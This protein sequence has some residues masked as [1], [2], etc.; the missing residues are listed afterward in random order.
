MKIFRATFDA[1]KILYRSVLDLIK[2][3]GMIYAAATSFYFLLSFFPVILLIVYV[4]VQTLGFVYKGVDVSDISSHLFRYIKEILP[5]L[6]ENIVS[7]LSK[8]IK[9]SRRVG[10]AGL[11][12]LMLSSTAVAESLIQAART[13]FKVQKAHLVLS[14]ILVI[15]IFLG[16]G[17]LLALLLAIT[18]FLSNLVMQYFPAIFKFVTIYKGNLLF[19]TIIPILLI[20]I[21]YIVITYMVLPVKKRINI[22]AKVGVF[23]TIFFMLAKMFYGYYLRNITKMTVFYGGISALV[24]L[25]LWVFYI[26]TLYLISL[27]IIKNM[28]NKKNKEVSNDN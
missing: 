15:A 9:S 8:I 6:P 3:N 12:A 21:S 26:T 4:S 13:I 11:I 7:E 2:D 23:F 28:S 17:I 27:E 19:S 10:I 5:F 1:I 20:F 14:K 22:I 16:V 24:V 25:V 18:S